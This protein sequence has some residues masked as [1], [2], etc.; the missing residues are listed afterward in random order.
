MRRLLLLPLV[1]LVAACADLAGNDPGPPAAGQAGVVVHVG[2]GDSLVVEVDGIEEKVRLI[3]INAPELDECFGVESKARLESLVFDRPV[4]LVADVETEDQYGR[5]LRYVYLDGSLIN[6]DLVAGGF[7]M[8]RSY[9]PNT[10]RQGDFDAAE[11]L[12]RE[13]G[14]GMWANSTCAVHSD[15]QI[16]F[17]QAD[18]PGPD[19]E[20]LNGEW[21]EI[22]NGGLETQLLTGWSL[23]DAESVHRFTFPVGT[24]L[25]PGDSLRISTGC[26]TDERRLLHWC[27]GGPVW[28]NGGDVAFLLDPD[29]RI[30][31]R[32]KY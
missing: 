5:M 17:V 24:S 3:G 8:A 2:D 22:T 6:E 23:R 15:L 28:N 25:E 11:D 18:A 32:Y 10:S 12:A 4:V 7:A 31:D 16:D 1:F 13:T 14:R 27:S 19:D 20:N 26:G 21:V 9:E 30:A 29:G